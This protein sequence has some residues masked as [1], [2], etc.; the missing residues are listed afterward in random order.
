MTGVLKGF[1]GA[2]ELFEKPT[3]VQ[4]GHPFKQ[5]VVVQHRSDMLLQEQVR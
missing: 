5:K 3:P 4:M 2:P 1:P